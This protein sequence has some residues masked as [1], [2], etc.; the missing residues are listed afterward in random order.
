MPGLLFAT[1]PYPST[2]HLVLRWVIVAVLVTLR[3]R[4]AQPIMEEYGATG[5]VCAFSAILGSVFL[6]NMLL[7]SDRAYDYHPQIR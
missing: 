2:P 1:C 7:V 6:H 4:L 5:L 3:G